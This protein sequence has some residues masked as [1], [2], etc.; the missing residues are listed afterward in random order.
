MIAQ[1]GI[2]QRSAF[3]HHPALVI[4]YI[5]R[6][7]LRFA[8]VTVVTMAFLIGRFPAIPALTLTG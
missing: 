4:H 8:P 3:A 7:Q 1:G 2:M 5:Q 6:E